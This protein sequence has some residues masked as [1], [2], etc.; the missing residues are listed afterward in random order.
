MFKNYC[1]LSKK[2]LSHFPTEWKV[3]H[4]AAND[5][6]KKQRKDKSN[7]ITGKQVEI[8]RSATACKVDVC[9]AFMYI[10]LIL[11]IVD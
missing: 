9:F 10:K 4:G 2:R 8:T 7:V 11:S 5:E 1:L 3:I 6:A